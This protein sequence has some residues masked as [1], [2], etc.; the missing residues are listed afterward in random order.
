MI[1]NSAL[2]ILDTGEEMSSTKCSRASVQLEW[3]AMVR[4]GASF[5]VA[6][7]PRVRMKRNPMVKKTNWATGGPSSRWIHLKEKIEYNFFYMRDSFR[8][9]CQRFSFV[10]LLFFSGRPISF[11]ESTFWDEKKNS[12]KVTS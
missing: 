5:L 9:F 10:D 8:Q 2:S 3:G 6:L 1:G 4:M 12:P 7:L 11:S